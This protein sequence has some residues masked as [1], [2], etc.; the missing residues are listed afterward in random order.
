MPQVHVLV[1]LS[2]PAG[3]ARIAIARI[4]TGRCSLPCDDVSIFA[5]LISRILWQLAALPLLI[6]GLSLFAATAFSSQFG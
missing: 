5:S 6:A 3:T 1:W 4:L 2:V